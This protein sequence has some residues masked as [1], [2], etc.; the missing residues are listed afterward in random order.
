MSAAPHVQ[1]MSDFV[2]RNDF[3]AQASRQLLDAQVSGRPIDLLS[4]SLGWF[5]LDEAYNV[6]RSV[7]TSAGRNIAGYK[8]GYTKAAIR[9]QMQI[10]EP[11]YGRYSGDALLLAEDSHSLNLGILIH[12]RVEPE[13]TIVL[14]S[15][16]W[17]P[18]LTAGDAARAIGNA[19]MSLEIV[20]TRYKHYKFTPVDNIADNSSAARCILGNPIDVEQLARNADLTVIL[21]CE[22]EEIDRDRLGAIWSECCANLAWLA[23]KLAAMGTFL[24]G[25]TFVMMGAL[26][27]AHPMKR[28]AAYK[29]TIPGI[30]SI[31]STF[32]WESRH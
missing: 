29:A 4:E 30:G 20:D 16:L 22:G 7:F 14:S 25:G 31:A 21:D 17:G 26:T 15:P 23:N 10:F 9:Q 3:L 11:N 6:G 24:A 28:G 13:I 19:H 5:T 2:A 27:R 1:S 8:L 12:P 18:D 32:D